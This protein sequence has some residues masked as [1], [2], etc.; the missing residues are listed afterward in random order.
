MV[1][2][3]IF[4]E[5]NIL[6][7]YF[8]FLDFQPS[9]S[10]GDETVFAA[11][12]YDLDLHR[13]A[14]IFTMICQNEKTET[15]VFALSL[16]KDMMKK[17]GKD[18]KPKY[19]MADNAS[20]IHNACDEVLEKGFYFVTCQQHFR[21]SYSAK[22]KSNLIGS[23]R[24]KKE[25]TNFAESLLTSCQSDD[26][27]TRISNNFEEWQKE[28]K[29]RYSYLFSW[30]AW[31]YARRHLWSN[32]FRDAK[33]AKTNEAEKGNSRYRGN[34]GTTKLDLLKLTE[35][36][37][38]EHLAHVNI[39][40]MYRKGLHIPAQV[41][42]GR[43]QTL[44]KIHDQEEK[45]KIGSPVSQKHAE[46]LTVKL[47][48]K[49]KGQNESETES[50]KS[51]F[52][53]DS[54][55]MDKDASMTASRVPH[56]RVGGHKPPEKQ[57]TIFHTTKKSKNKTEKEIDA[58]KNLLKFKPNIRKQNS[59]TFVFPS[60][61]GKEYTLRLKPSFHCSCPAFM[62]QKQNMCKHI[63][64][65]LLIIGVKDEVNYYLT[66]LEKANIDL[67]IEN[68]TEN[69]IEDNINKILD[70]KGKQP[71]KQSL[72]PKPMNC[73]LK[74]KSKDIA[75]QTLKNNPQHCKWIAAKAENN[76]LKCPSHELEPQ[77]AREK[78]KKMPNDICSGQLMFVALYQRLLKERNL[79]A[80]V[81]EKRSFHT[82]ES[83]ITNFS[84]T[85][86]EWSS[87]TR[88]T[89][90][91]CVGLKNKE[92]ENLQKQFPNITFEKEELVTPVLPHQT[93]KG[94]KKG[95]ESQKKKTDD[96][97]EGGMFL[98]FLASF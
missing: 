96:W 66:D 87:I 89:T 52:E 8:S 30:W 50:S 33:A 15:C 44:Q 98:S 62:F 56:P 63:V 27:F 32:A 78:G 53:I 35:S 77:H 7:I 29:K 34:L 40:K 59:G 45:R 86:T 38:F 92:I 48:K 14:P 60:H 13:I 31:W 39:Y 73:H 19:V 43:S 55:F 17:N 3:R 2:Q 28:D 23:E 21:I 68:F 11:Y 41:K 75:I 25:F 18:M 20:S 1:C 36:H 71:R 83:C 42:R 67:K 85:L 70:G 26:M 9:R 4:G 72:P 79:L 91:K 95:G 69:C 65:T 84:N 16:M 6:L 24:D 49:I 5:L 88:P 94:A 22:S 76:R 47:M 10:K 58:I 82:S 80:C 81:G 64:C 51:D 93:V 12:V 57:K 61:T 97:L 90:M 46:K 37:T 54:E 74:F